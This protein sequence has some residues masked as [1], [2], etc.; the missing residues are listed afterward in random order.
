MDGGVNP[1]VERAGARAL[2]AGILEQ[3]VAF[4]SGQVEQAERLTGVVAG[5][6]SYRAC[7]PG[8]DFLLPAWRRSMRDC[9]TEVIR[10]SVQRKL[11]SLCP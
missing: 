9:P 6:W 3:A 2:H 11:A 1:L 8:P 5:H 7:V 4:R 10:K